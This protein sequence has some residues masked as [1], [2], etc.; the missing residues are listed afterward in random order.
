[1]SFET[2]SARDRHV[3][4]C[5]KAL[6]IRFSN[7]EVDIKFDSLQNGYICK[8]TSNKCKGIYA[9]STTFTNHLEDSSLWQESEVLAYS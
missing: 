1:M 2:R 4:Q 3:T 7:K 9:N 6:T 8:C 5:G